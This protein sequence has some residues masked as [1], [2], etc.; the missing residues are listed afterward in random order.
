M[1]EEV[2]ILAVDDIEDNLVALAAL[3]KRP[4][5][6]LIKARSGSQ[7]LEALL[8]DDIAL[9]LL[10]VNMPEMDGF[11]LAE[12]MRGSERT[13]QVPIIFLTAA[14]PDRRRVFEGYEAGAVDFLFKPLD[15]HLL[16]SKVEVFAQFHRQ[17]RQLARQLEQIQQAQAMS[18]L[19]IAVLGHDLRNPLSNVVASAAMIDQE[20]QDLEGTRRKARIIARACGRMDRLIQQVLDFALARVKGG[21]PVEPTDADLAQIAHR[22]VAELEP[23][24]AERI[25][26]EVAG[27]TSGRWD[28]DRMMQVV[29]NLVA[30]ALEHG[31]PK[32]P[33]VIRA[34]GLDKEVVFEVHNG[35]VI[36]AATLPVLFSPFKPRSRPSRGLG[37]GLYIVDQ[38][39]RAH[40]G[41]VTV[42]SN[43][44]EGSFITLRFPR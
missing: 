24:A 12:L 2:N 1:I 39:V 9:A 14:V 34:A 13:R 41:T 5:L 25:S 44:P 15:P 43:E 23:A 21:I 37:L 17:K 30:N 32:T 29:S 22:A 4:G 38:I 19:F 11:E 16:A 26:V 3:L 40:G 35:G 33:I 8:A 6:R 27:D 36:P 31:A 28:P 7:A 42:R 18:D 20:P 10:D